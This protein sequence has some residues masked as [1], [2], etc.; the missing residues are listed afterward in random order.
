MNTSG[1][2]SSG[3]NESSNSGG[4]NTNGSG[5]GVCVASPLS[6]GIIGSDR[7]IDVT[8]SAPGYRQ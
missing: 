5:A 7:T 1:S 6:V 2:Y 3:G 4:S 8:L